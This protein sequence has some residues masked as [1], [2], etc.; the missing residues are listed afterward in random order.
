MGIFVGSTS[1]G[2]VSE[3]WRVRENSQVC[4]NPHGKCNETSNVMLDPIAEMLTRIRNAQRAGHATVSVPASNVKRAV[5]DILVR[6][7]FLDS[8]ETMVDGA[9][10]NLLMRLKYERISST[11][12]KGAIQEIERVSKEGLRVYVKRGD[13]ERVKYGYGIAILSTSQGIMTGKD[14]YRKGL[15]GEY[16]CKVW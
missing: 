16:L 15:G 11:E 7:G 5:A 12:K 1:V 8:I 3:S 10:S 9:R 2:S 4:G 6:E 14:A 13:V